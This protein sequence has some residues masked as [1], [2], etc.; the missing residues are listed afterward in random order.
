MHKH[1]R[2][3]QAN[4]SVRVITV[5]LCHYMQNY[6]K[7]QWKTP[8]QKSTHQRLYT[9]FIYFCLSVTIFIRRIMR[10][11]Q[12]STDTNKSVRVKTKKYIIKLTTSIF[13]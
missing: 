8:K 9:L 1:F 2:E 7:I 4:V 11:E 5:I 12:C 13:N 3:L 6:E 10:A